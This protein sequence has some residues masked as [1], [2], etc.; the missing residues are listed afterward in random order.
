[1]ISR[2]NYRSVV[3]MLVGAL[4]LGLV[5]QVTGATRDR[6]ANGAA[7]QSSADWHARQGLYYKRN[8]GVDIIGVKPVSSGFML[9]F[10]YRIVDPEKAKVLHDQHSKAYLR[11]L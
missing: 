1:M 5:S 8:W 9:A 11:D 7:A 2:K 3:P 10:R 4:A 6:P